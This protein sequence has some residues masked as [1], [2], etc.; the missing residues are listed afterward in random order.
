MIKAILRLPVGA[1][2][3][4]AVVDF[5][6]SRQVL[7]RAR[8]GAGCASAELLVSASASEILV[9]SMWSSAEAYQSWVGS[10]A[11]SEEAV[12]LRCLLNGDLEPAEVYEV[13]I[14]AGN[15]VVQ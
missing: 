4:D 3:L 7:Q 5:Y 1:G 9:T 14:R 15:E 2:D 12:E 6:T 10:S 8:A 11:R 13:V